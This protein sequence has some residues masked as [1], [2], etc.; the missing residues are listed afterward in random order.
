MI[1]GISSSTKDLFG[2]EPYIHSF[3]EN[4]KE[5]NAHLHE[6]TTVPPERI[7]VVAHRSKI[8]VFMIIFENELLQN[9]SFPEDFCRCTM[10]ELKYFLMFHQKKLNV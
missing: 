1:F 3:T 9:T 10:N 4:P 5:Q 8:Y 2:E 6:E 7:I